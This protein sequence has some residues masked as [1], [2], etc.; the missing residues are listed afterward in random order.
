MGFVLLNLFEIT[1][2]CQARIILDDL[3]QITLMLGSKRGLKIEKKVIIYQNSNRKC[4]ILN[5]WQI[6]RIFP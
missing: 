5:E 3:W 2:N 6:N 1:T 4:N